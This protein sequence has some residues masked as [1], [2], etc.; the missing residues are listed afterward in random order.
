MT[1]TLSGAGT[2]ATA[3]S[4]NVNCAADGAGCATG[5]NP[6][7]PGH[8]CFR[9]EW[10]G[11]SNYVGKLTFD[12]SNECFEVTVIPTLIST[13]QFYYPNDTATIQTSDN[14]ALPAG[15]VTFN[16]YNSSANCTAGTT[17]QSA[18]RLYGPASFTVG[19]GSLP[20][21]SASTANTTVKI[22]NDGTTL[23][24]RVDFHVTANAAYTDSH[25]TCVENTVYTVG[26]G[27]TD[28]AT[29]TNDKT[30]HS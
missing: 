13:V 30:P 5:E 20:S 16:L 11:D 29:I 19:G 28:T 26:T 17:P 27:D 6:L 14:S 12:G 4:P 2:T 1:G 24:W 23:Y 22:P 10:P 15:T 18:G 21:A 3:D 25:S 8:Y 9:A 7:A